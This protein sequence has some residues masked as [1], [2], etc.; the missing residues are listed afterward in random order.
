MTTEPE[1]LKPCP[2]CGSL[3]A[4]AKE[5]DGD[6]GPLPWTVACGGESCAVEIGWYPTVAGARGAWNRRAPT[7]ADTGRRLVCALLDARQAVVDAVNDRGLHA[8]ADADAHFDRCEMALA[9]WEAKAATPSPSD[10]R[11]R[12]IERASVEL[13]AAIDENNG[14]EC[15]MERAAYERESRAY[16]A[17][18]KAVKG[19]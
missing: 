1:P 6:R 19:E 2:F 7:D 9:D 18:R 4:Y 15:E 8:T 5:F 12:E 14:D 16:T 11:L 17:L 3:G 13:L 10:A